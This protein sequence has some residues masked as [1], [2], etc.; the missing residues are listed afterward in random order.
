MCDEIRLQVPSDVA[1]WQKVLCHLIEVVLVNGMP[2]EDL[3]VKRNLN[4]HSAMQQ[5]RNAEEALLAVLNACARVTQ[6]ISTIKWPSPEAFAA[7]ISR[8]QGQRTGVDNVLVFECLSLLNLQG[9][10]L[11]YKNFFKAELIA[12]NAYRFRTA[13]LEGA[14]L[15][16]ANLVRANLEGANLRGANLRGANLRGAN[17]RGAN[18]E[19]ANLRGANL[20]GA[21]L[22]GTILEGKDI[23]SLTENPN[24]DSEES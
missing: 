12:E 9:C 19:R 24:E 2:M 11:Y 1:K 14:N 23:A 20:R 10:F 17:L 16:G 7:W 4:F 18:L 22:K 5:A 6:E 21:N 3:I 15:R 13:N 8:L